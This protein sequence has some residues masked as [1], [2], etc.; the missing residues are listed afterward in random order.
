MTDLGSISNAANINAQIAALKNEKNALADSTEGN[1]QLEMEKNF[2]TMLNRLMFTSSNDNS[3]GSVDNSIW[4]SL[5]SINDK[6]AQ[7]QDTADTLSRLKTLENSSPLL[8]KNVVYFDRT[9]AAE[10]SDIVDQIL[11]SSDKNSVLVTLKSGKQISIN[12]IIG[13]KQ[14]N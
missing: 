8:G 7:Y 1:Y 13:L 6:Q 10:M 3:S 14:T 5:S 9:T 2:S 11:L 4:D 12:D